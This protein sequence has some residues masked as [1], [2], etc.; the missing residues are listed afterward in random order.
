MNNEHKYFAFNDHFM[1]IFVVSFHL[2]N[3]LSTILWNSKTYLRGF[4]LLPISYTRITHH[5]GII[6]KSYGL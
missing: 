4:I 6:L 5:R 1:T 2:L 3:K